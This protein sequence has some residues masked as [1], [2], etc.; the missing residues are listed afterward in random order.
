MKRAKARYGRAAMLFGSLALV[1]GTG[2]VTVQAGATTPPSTD[3]FEVD[4]NLLND[5][6]TP[7]LD[8][9]APGG[10]GLPGVIT[11]TRNSDG[12]CTAPTGA[13]VLICDPVKTDATTFPG[14]A[15]EPDPSG[16][17][18]IG[19]SQVTPKTDITNVYALGRVDASGDP[20]ILNGME[21]L[22]KAGDVHLDFEF[23]QQVTGSGLTQIP[24]RQVN[25]LL[26]AYD[27]GGSVS[28][29]TGSLNV[30]IFKAKLG[31]GCN[32]ACPGYDYSNPDA[33]LNGSGSFPQ[34]G[35]GVTAAMNTASI[36]AGPWQAYDDHN[37]LVN[38]IGAFGF[39]EA[40]ID[41]QQ[42]VG[43]QSIC[44]NYVTVKSRSSESVTSQL[45]DTTG[46]VNFPFC[47]GLAVHKYID[48]NQNGAK[49]TGEANGANWS[50]TV[51]GPAAGGG[52]G[53]SVC[54]GTTN[55][56]GDLVCPHAAGTADPLSGLTAGT[57]RV[58]ETQKTPGWFNSDPG[59]SATDIY[60][61]GASVSKDVTVSIGGLRTV[62]FGNACFNAVT[63]Q[64]NNVPSSA[65]TV[66]VLYSSTGHTTATNVDV[67]LTLNTTTHV[68]SGTVSNTFVLAD[69]ITWRWYLN[70]VSGNAV[71]G[72]STTLS[73][74]ASTESASFAPITVSGTKYK[75]ANG[76]GTRD[77]TETGM[78]GFV[79]ELK[80]GGTV[81]QTATA[82]ATGA[83]SFT[84]VEP[85]TYSV[86]EQS[87]TGW[88]QTEPSSGDRSVTVLL[89]DTSKQVATFGNTPL[90][91][92][93]V[94]FRNQAVLP[95][96]PSIPATTATIDCG[97]GNGTQSVN[98]LSAI[99]LKTGTYTC[100]VVIVDP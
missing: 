62:D 86:H 13:A 19:P 5:V 83:Y 81:L 80:A 21:R 6:Q 25:D 97:S 56:S 34:S 66:N 99:G 96:T 27:L 64:V 50:F 77:T 14:G 68:A 22:P 28:N 60:N 15:K 16:W 76:N 42:T 67:P 46:T 4:G 59:N 18:P 82:D 3:T 20:I 8:D 70:G 44:V 40:G 29:N 35:S 100:T 10:T 92:I 88:R 47:G 57:Y 87:Q 43:L 7:A 1:A 61:T 32:G 89:T 37:Q 49:D 63:F 55:A 11:Q 2:L 84:N 65:T 53:P 69:A 39:A 93:T 98:T 23:N 45:K 85:G 90:S 48:A 24:N 9:W 30:R 73:G 52:I 94:T 36:D 91:D 12:T 41:V 17:L 51:Y 54:T 58:T 33:T 38:T 79:F 78:G 72:A 95:L 26:I 71:S 31:F 75:D 74:C